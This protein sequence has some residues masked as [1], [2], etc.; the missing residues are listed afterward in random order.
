MPPGRKPPAP[1]RTT[2]PAPVVTTRKVTRALDVTT[3]FEA[4]EALTG[5]A[6]QE[7]HQ[8]PPTFQ[9]ERI[10]GPRD[11]SA[12]WRFNIPGPMLVIAEDDLPLIRAL[13]AELDNERAARQL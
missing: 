13:I 12:R 5:R 8:A 6:D 1:V 7:L 2:A 11:T 4:A 10:A 9:V 3:S